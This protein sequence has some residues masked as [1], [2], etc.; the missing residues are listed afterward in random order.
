MS[1]NS[2]QCEVIR[3]TRKRSP[4]QASYSIQGHDLSF[5][6]SGKYLGVTLSDNLAWNAHAD[7]TAKKSNN[8]LAFLRRNL[9]RCH[10]DTKAQC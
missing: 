6:K 10:R 5:V 1:F 7:I 2:T 9:A 8:I 3:I 4:I